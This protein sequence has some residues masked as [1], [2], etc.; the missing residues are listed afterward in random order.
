M[1]NVT[2]TIP[3]NCELIKEGNTYVIK[4]KD[5][6][7][8][9]WE[10]FC[11]KFPRQSGECFIDNDGEILLA[12]DFNSIDRRV[13]EDKNVLYNR[14]EAEAFLALMQLRQLR[15]A[16]VGDWEPDGMMDFNAIRHDISYGNSAVATDSYHF[17]TRALSFP[18]KKMAEEFLDC[19]KDLLET[20]K[21]LL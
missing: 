8:K 12:A 10:E 20:A 2:I 16:W 3:D 11:E 15:K 5:I 6:K 7:P 18:T 4:E 13:F 1:K 21:V 14:K 9:S 19:F 17:Q